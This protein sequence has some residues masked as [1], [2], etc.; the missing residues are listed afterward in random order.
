[1]FKK[2][3]LLFFLLII[4]LGFVFSQ[5]NSKHVRVS[6]YTRKDGTYVQP[7]F[8]TAP[9]ST[10]RDNFSTKGNVNPYTGKAGWIESRWLAQFYCVIL[11]QGEHDGN[12]SCRACMSSLFGIHHKCQE[13]ERP[14][15]DGSLLCCTLHHL[16]S[17]II[18]DMRSPFPPTRE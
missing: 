12:D 16:A 7:Y 14:E 9:N 3:L 8:R 6:G 10:N 13:S 5:T 11:K 18:P 2:L 1:M 17:S 15:I 4:C